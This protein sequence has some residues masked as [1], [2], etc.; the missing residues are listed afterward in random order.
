MIDTNL[1]QEK[2]NMPAGT[3]H[4]SSIQIQRTAA[5]AV[6]QVWLASDFFYLKSGKKE[7]KGMLL[8]GIS[9]SSTSFKKKINDF[10]LMGCI[11]KS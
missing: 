5:A 1:T 4:A 9:F 11:W 3:K 7:E 2:G 6:S 8:R 10:D